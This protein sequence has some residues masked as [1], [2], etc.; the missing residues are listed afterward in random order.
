[1]GKMSGR[2]FYRTKRGREWLKCVIVHKLIKTKM[3]EGLLDFLA[4][5]CYFFF[6]LY[7]KVFSVSVVGWKKETRFW[8]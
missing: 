3:G 8:H 6:F 7:L 5:R 4:W 2:G 1:M